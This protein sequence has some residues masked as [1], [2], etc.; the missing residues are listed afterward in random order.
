MSHE[1]KV[2]GSKVWLTM[3]MFVCFGVFLRPHLPKA[4]VGLA[5]AFAIVW[6]A[7]CIVW[8]AR[9]VIRQVREP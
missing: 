3:L 4:V 5:V 8:L 1:A 9:E 7:C 2:T 6:L